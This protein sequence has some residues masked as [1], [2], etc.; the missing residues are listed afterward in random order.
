MRKNKALGWIMGVEVG[1]NHLFFFYFVMPLSLSF[2]LFP[3]FLSFD[4][5]SIS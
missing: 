4:L 3:P 5:G 2:S 1:L